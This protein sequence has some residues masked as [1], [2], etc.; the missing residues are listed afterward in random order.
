MVGAEGKRLP[1]SP[2]DMVQRGK[3]AQ[4]RE[5]EVHAGDSV[6][7]E[8]K[9][10]QSPGEMPGPLRPGGETRPAEARLQAGGGEALRRPTLTLP[11]V[12]CE[13]LAF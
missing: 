7:S 6:C 11:F 12:H 13:S 1:P 8:R 4:P 10:P 2:T 3:S 9:R 5:K